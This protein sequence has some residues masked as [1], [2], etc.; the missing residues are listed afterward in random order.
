MEE[1]SFTKKILVFQ[2]GIAVLLIVLGIQIT[3]TTRRN[4]A[5]LEQIRTDLV[6]M[7]ELSS[8]RMEAV[9]AKLEIIEE[10]ID[11][12]AEDLK[13][14]LITGF[15]GIKIPTWQ[16]RDNEIINMMAEKLIYDYTAKALEYF[17]DADYENASNTFSLAM[18]YQRRNSTLLF[19]HVYA[20]FLR[21]NN[22]PLTEN[23]LA[24][25]Q[26]RITEL[27]ERGFREQ[28][29][30]DFTVEEMEQKV[31]EMAYNI[32]EMRLQ[33]EQHTSKKNEI[34]GIIEE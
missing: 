26:A 18:K 21:R 25:I 3:I 10:E 7:E 30:L 12:E 2:T 13:G 20:L 32:K 4:N 8:A 17:R 11:E 15:N 16:S 27:Q 23:E 34:S 22:A 19:Y 5:I 29:R 28:E 6:N 14:L 24:I 31:M 33:M 9:M 1:V